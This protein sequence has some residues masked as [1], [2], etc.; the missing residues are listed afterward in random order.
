MTG[1]KMASDRISGEEGNVLFLILIAVVLFAA[2]SYAVTRSTNASSGSV[3][4]ESN[5]IAAA[6]IIQYPAGLRASIIRMTIGGMNAEDLRFDIPSDF[7]GLSGF[8]DQVF[9]PYGGGATWTEAPA[10]L[11]ENE[12][13][14]RWYFNAEFEIENIGLNS[15]SENRGNEIIAF[16]PGIKGGICSIINNDL[17]LS[18]VPTIATDISTRYSLKMTVTD[19]YALPSDEVVL[20]VSAG[21]GSAVIT[22]QPFGCFLNSNGNYVYYHVLADR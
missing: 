10:D 18:G 8:T 11:M 19:G 14:G 4:N 3:D 7:S 16:L 22:G 20:G 1:N 2:L 17:G 21:N 12:M 5:K 6:Q 9:H 15:V 13:P